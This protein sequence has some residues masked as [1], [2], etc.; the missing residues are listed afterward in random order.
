MTVPPVTTSAVT[1]SVTPP[2]TTSA[3]TSSVTPPVTTSPV[4]AIP[5]LAPERAFAFFPAGHGSTKA[6]MR[7]AALGRE[8][9]EMIGGLE[10]W[11]REGRPTEGR[12][13]VDPRTAT[14]VDLGLVRRPP[15]GAA[16]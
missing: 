13:P 1:S 9:E 16:R 15:A 10:Y 14:A 7:L 2:V 12:R 3:V 6:A 11:I 5:A 4:T 8:V